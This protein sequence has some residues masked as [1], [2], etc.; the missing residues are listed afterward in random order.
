MKKLNQATQIEQVRLAN[1]PGRT[2][3]GKKN[4]LKVNQKS[5]FL[6]YTQNTILKYIKTQWGFLNYPPEEFLKLS[7][8]FFN[9]A[10]DSSFSFQMVVCVSRLQPQ[11]K[12]MNVS[13]TFRKE[14]DET[15]NW[16]MSSQDRNKQVN[17]T[18]LANSCNVIKIIQR[19]IIYFCCF[20]L[21]T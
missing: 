11:W 5:D 8:T 12:Q 2:S 20:F 21:T 17:K 10:R 4:C 1:S 6:K 18:P 3:Q 19:M 7:V 16:R 9:D 15:D 13:K 14:K